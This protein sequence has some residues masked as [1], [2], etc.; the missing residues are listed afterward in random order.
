MLVSSALTSDESSESHEESGMQRQ[1][2]YNCLLD[3]IKTQSSPSEVNYYNRTFKKY[4]EFIPDEKLCNRFIDRIST[5]FYP[6]LSRDLANEE[7]LAKISDCI[8]ENLKQGN[9][10]IYTIKHMF[11]GIT[12]LSRRKKKKIQRGIKYSMERAIDAATN[13]CTFEDSQSEAFDDLVKSQ[14]DSQ[15]DSGKIQDYC[16]RKH[17]VDNGF[18]DTNV[19]K[20]ELNPANVNTTGVNCFKMV[21][22]VKSVYDEI[23]LAN[24]ET[25]FDRITSKKVK[26]IEKT[27]DEHNYFET[28]FRIVFLTESPAF[29][30]EQKQIEKKNYIEKMKLLSTDV[31]KC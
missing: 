7:E 6:G 26:C 19:Y 18:I 29:T 4:Q 12:K 22:F 2:T 24:F 25:S 1:E 9:F 27:I 10:S 23:M 14:G 30:D 21:V 20:I 31:F 28:S 15:T 3:Y 16:V 17:L 13:A 11:N 5:D 8:T